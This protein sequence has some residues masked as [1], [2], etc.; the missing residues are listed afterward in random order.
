MCLMEV[1]ANAKLV[2][3]LQCVRVTNQYAVHL[4]LTQCIRQSYQ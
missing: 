1:L 3:I 2:I 4:K